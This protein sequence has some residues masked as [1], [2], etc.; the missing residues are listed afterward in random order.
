[1]SNTL[2]PVTEGDLRAANGEACEPA[3][4][5]TVAGCCP[6]ADDTAAK[7]NDP[8]TANGIPADSR[9]ACPFPSVDGAAIDITT[10]EHVA[11]SAGGVH[12]DGE[13][14]EPLAHV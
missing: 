7:I 2:C 9:G 12:L 5:I 6:L 13:S 4:D 10:T 11:G 1:M 8:D 3:D 14:R